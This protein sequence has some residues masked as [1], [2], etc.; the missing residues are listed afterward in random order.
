M[1]TIIALAAV[2][3]CTLSTPAFA[4]SDAECQEMW[5]KAD[6]DKD[7]KLTGTEGMRYIAFMRVNNKMLVTEGTVTQSEF[8]EACKGDTYKARAN[9]AGA[10]L[11]GASSFTEGQAKDRAIAHGAM[12]VSEMK[13]DNDG[14]WRGT[15]KGPDGRAAQVAVDY[16]GNVVFSAQ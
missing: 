3:G 15:G 2:V 9:D 16:K 10:P 14:I 4:A 8:M 13:K 6:G 11:K 5:T 1:R 12:S 7:G